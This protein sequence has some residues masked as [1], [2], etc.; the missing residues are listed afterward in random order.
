MTMPVRFDT[1]QFVKTLVDAGV[2]REHAEAHAD[3]LKLALSQPVANDADRAISRA[4]MRT[5]LAELELR[6]TRKM[7]PLW[8]LNIITLIL[9][10]ANTVKIFF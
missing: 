5:L 10:S 1:A 2:L 8:V 3:A 9:V 7:R 4:E 6:L